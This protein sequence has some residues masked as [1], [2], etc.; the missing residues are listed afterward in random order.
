[1]I[2]MDLPSSHSSS[3]KKRYVL[4]ACAAASAGAA[5]YWWLKR[6]QQ[7]SLAP[8]DFDAFLHSPVVPSRKSKASAAAAASATSFESFLKIQP[9]ATEPC[10][11]DFASFLKDSG[12]GVGGQ[13]AAQQQEQQQQQQQHE[14][15]PEDAVP[16]L[17]LYGTEYGFAREIAEKLA[18]QLKDSGKLW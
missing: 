6:G 11:T 13:E 18:Q 17:V 4:A 9:V 5:G 14:P 1:M 2:T 8:T 10:S 15:I 16:V 3:T 12:V 7:Q